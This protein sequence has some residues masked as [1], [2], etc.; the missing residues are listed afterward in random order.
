PYTAGV[1][2]LLPRWMFFSAEEIARRELVLANI[3]A[4]DRA[5]EAAAA[6]CAE[7]VRWVYYGAKTSEWDKRRFPPLTDLRASPALQT[8]FTQSGAAVFRLA[9]PCFGRA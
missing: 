5:P 7:H 6:A 9:L 3:T 8:V 1:P 2:V 4:L